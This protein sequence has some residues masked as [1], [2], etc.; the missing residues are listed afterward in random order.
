MNE[1]SRE[2]YLLVDH[3]A[4]PGFTPQQVRDAGIDADPRLLGEGKTFEAPTVTCS[5]CMT[6]F[7]I[8]PDRKRERTR[9]YQCFH[10][11][12]DNC[13]V[14]YKVDGI[15]RSGKRLADEVNSGRFPLTGTENNPGLLVPA[16]YAKERNH[17]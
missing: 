6:S 14:A 13:A 1:R 5:H 7:V 2:G 16:A 11:I 9:C 10:Y 17:G 8:N 4:S 12:C 3:R 15:C